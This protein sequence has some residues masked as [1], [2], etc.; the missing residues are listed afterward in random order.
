MKPSRRKKQI[1]RPIQYQGRKAV[2]FPFN[3]F[4]RLKGQQPTAV[5]LKAGKNPTILALN[6]RRGPAERRVGKLDRRLK[7]AKRSYETI[8]GYDPFYGDAII[9]M[10]KKE[11]VSLKGQKPKV[12]KTAGG[13]VY[14]LSRRKGAWTRR[15][16]DKD[17]ARRESAERQDEENTARSPFTID[18]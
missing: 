8:A 17:K 6:R 9:K 18:W 13:Y 11:F 10:T 2:S 12:L 1:G 5:F 4:L 7:E 16:G 15:K 14:F 3:S